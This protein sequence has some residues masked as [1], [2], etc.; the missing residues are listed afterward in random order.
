MTEREILVRA[1]GV[2]VHLAHRR[3]LNKV[4]LEVSSGEIVTL[5]G[6]NGAGKSTLVR[7]LVG[8]IQPDSGTVFRKPNARVGFCPQHVNRDTTLPITVKRFLTLGAKATQ[9]E[10]ETV[11]AEVGAESVLHSQIASLSGGELHRVLLARALL[12]SPELLVL[13]EPLAGV[14]V[15]SQSELYRLIAGI[16]DQRRCGVLL[17]SHDLHVVMAATDTVVCL[18][19][20]V[21]CTGHPESVAQHPEFISLF[22]KRMAEVLGVYTHDHDHRHD[23]AGGVVP[24]NDTESEEQPQSAISDLTPPPGNSHPPSSPRRD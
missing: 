4:N 7:T 5:I 13:D 23:E 19:H 12:R 3:I 9:K 16:R 1:T 14:D 8:L 20:H 22:G 15:S 24:F 10:L 18:N 11:L 2:T 17:V 6:L 21:C